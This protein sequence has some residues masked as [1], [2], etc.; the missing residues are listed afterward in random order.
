M[1]KVNEIA[2][3]LMKIITAMDYDVTEDAVTNFIKIGMENKKELLELFKDKLN[4]NMRIEELID[5]P[6]VSFKNLRD[7]RAIV[8][9]GI[10]AVFGLYK[11]DVF[12]SIV[13]L[14]KYGEKLIED[15]LCFMLNKTKKKMGQTFK[16]IKDFRVYYYNKEN[17]KISVKLYKGDDI[18]KIIM[19]A[20]NFGEKMIEKIYKKYKLQPEDIKTI[21]DILNRESTKE[22][23]QVVW[24]IIVERNS[25]HNIPKKIVLSFNSIDY[26]MCT[27]H[28][29][30]ENILSKPLKKNEYVWHFDD[31]NDLIERILPFQTWTIRDIL[32]VLITE[33]DES[34]A[35]KVKSI[36]LNDISYPRKFVA[37]WVG[38]DYKYNGLIITH[39]FPAKHKVYERYISEFIAKLFSEVLA[40]KLIVTKDY[41]PNPEYGQVF[42]DE[43]G[44]RYWEPPP[45]YHSFLFTIDYLGYPSYYIVKEETDKIL[46]MGHGGYTQYVCMECGQVKRFEHGNIIFPQLSICEECKGNYYEK[47][48]LCSKCLERV[49]VKNTIEFNGRLFC[50][51]CFKELQKD[52]SLK[53]RNFP[54][55]TKYKSWWGVIYSD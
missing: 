23:L 27:Y 28:F 19:L 21:S 13:D 8:R 40:C 44:E 35:V 42:V 54:K 41:E 43:D 34:T 20:P 36:T 46:Y 7:L 2:K 9:D 49:L 1:Y 55:I 15:Y 53:N 4:E 47:L 33:V 31:F 6:L 30:D 29:W 51:E 3:N 18:G 39:T 48:T 16:A 25:I 38:I 32:L 17:K 52:E 5:E 11:Y 22:F 45:P 10:R 37:A 50:Y 26:I 12:G 14:E 24:S